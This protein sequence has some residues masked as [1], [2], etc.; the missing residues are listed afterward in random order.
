[1]ETSSLCSSKVDNI[2]DDKIEMLYFPLVTLMTERKMD[3]EAI[4]M[5]TFRESRKDRKF[6]G[7]Q[8]QTA[9]QDKDIL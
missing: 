9:E 7:N 1:M 5:N 8:S 4:M 3:E 6:Y 2:K